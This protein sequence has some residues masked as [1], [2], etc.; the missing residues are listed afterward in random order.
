[1]AGEDKMQI[2]SHLHALKIPFV[3]PT[4]QGAVPR[5]VYVYLVYGEEVCLIDSGVASSQKIIFDYML[6]TGRRPEEISSLILTHSHP[7]HMG[8]ARSIKDAT[9]CSVAAHRNERAWIEDAEL[10]ARERPIPGFFSLVE[11]SVEVDRCLQEGDSL[12]LGGVEADVIHT[13]GHSSGS[14]SLWFPKEGAL[15]SADAVP[16]PDEL[17]IYED[18]LQSAASIRK[19]LA[20]EGIRFLLSSWDVPREGE[21]ARR[22]LEKGLLYL[23]RIHQAVRQAAAEGS[24]E[25]TRELCGQVLKDLG[26]D[27]SMANPLVA[28]SLQSHLLAIGQKERL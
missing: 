7:D 8:A 24:S 23:Q 5:F 28:R 12:D 21:D 27:E 2:T 14:I 10:Q 15:I 16:V 13:P 4:P 25:E 9:G 11:G 19:L 20:I 26:M 18:V 22:S 1:M 6:R 3:V 17:P